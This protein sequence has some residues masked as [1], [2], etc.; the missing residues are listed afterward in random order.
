VR[1]AVGDERHAYE[2]GER[3]VDRL[4]AR[5]PQSP[6]PALDRR[7]L[8]VE[9]EARA[10]FEH[11]TLATLP[12]SVAQESA[13]DR[14]ASLLHG[15]RDDPPQTIDDLRLLEAW[16]AIS[17]FAAWR[18][19]TLRW[20]GTGKKPIPPEWRRVGMRQD[21][22]RRSNRHARHPVNAMLNYGYAVLECQVRIAIAEVG[23]DLT[24]GYLHVCQ[25][26]RQALVYDLME[27]YRPR[28]DREVLALIRSRIFMPQDYVTDSNG[29]CRLHPELAR[30]AVAALVCIFEKPISFA[31]AQSILQSPVE[32]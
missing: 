3:P 27:P 20:K 13:I 4:I 22:R 23:L 21:V 28:V 26:G 10:V 29:V 16:A 7:L 2:I 14:V 1:D 25:P 31:V 15:L 5:G 19:I 18:T 8:L 24:I 32:Q 12:A 11:D 17:Y 30:Q 9:Q 6:E